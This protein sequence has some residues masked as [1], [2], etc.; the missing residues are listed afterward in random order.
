MQYAIPGLKMLN[1]QIQKYLAGHQHI[2]QNSGAERGPQT[3]YKP[4]M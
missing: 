4:M 1:A 3:P 2:R